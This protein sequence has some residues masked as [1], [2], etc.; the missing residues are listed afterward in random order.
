AFLLGCRLQENAVTPDD[1]RGIARSW[2]GRAPCD[3]VRLGPLD[4]H[5]FIVGD[6]FAVWSSE[7]RPILRVCSEHGTGERENRN[8]QSQSTPR[9]VHIVA[10][11][12]K[13]AVG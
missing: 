11:L 12:S 2:N 13:R 9:C 1:R 10:P 5:M 3:P 8:R 7:A 4:R 6:A